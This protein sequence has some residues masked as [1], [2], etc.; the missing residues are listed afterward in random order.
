MKK[1]IAILIGGGSKL[2]PILDYSDLNAKIV[3]V[4]SFKDK[5]EGIEL[6]RKKGIDTEY[7]RLKDYLKRGETRES[8]ENDLIN[9]LKKYDPDLIVLAGW[10]YL[11]SQKFIDLFE[12][13]VI[14][15]HPALLTDTIENT[16]TTS[17]NQTIL[18]FRG[19]DGIGDAFK[20][21]VNISGCTVHFVT[22]DMDAGPVILKKE[23]N[24]TSGD[25]LESFTD[26]VH[27]A[28]DEILPKAIKLF[29][30]DKLK[31]NAGKIEI[32]N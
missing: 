14:N 22:A 9:Y 21:G 17:D 18:V 31:V 28:E 8:F 24:R 6:A 27:D 4:V 26:K 13:N 19:K 2:K 7:F 1:K 16:I 10:D 15:L 5:S 32:L 12:G 3:T 30:K 11:V 23:V 20:A 29:C 25:T